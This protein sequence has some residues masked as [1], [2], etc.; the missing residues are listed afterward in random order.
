MVDGICRTH[1][2]L[3]ALCCA[4]A[5]GCSN[6]PWSDSGDD[7]ISRGFDDPNRQPYSALAQAFP[8]QQQGTSS[9]LPQGEPNQ[10]LSGENAFTT[11]F[12]KA[13]NA[14]TSALTIEPKVVPPDDPTS[15]AGGNQEPGADLH[16][17]AARVCES[18]SNVPAAAAHYQQS[19]ALDSKNVRTLIA[20]ARLLDRQANFHEAE[21]LYHQALQLEPDN[22]IASNDIGMM[23]ARQGMYDAALQALARAV[24]LQPA[25]QRYRNN[26][27][28][29]LIDAGRLDDAFM[30][31]AAVHG[32]AA[33]HYNLGYL[34]ARRGANNQAMQQLRLAI[35]LN[36]YLAPANQLLT[37]LSET[38]NQM[39]PSPPSHAPVN[40]AIYPVNERVRDMP[41][42]AMQPLPPI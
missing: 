9:P 33:A 6:S 38:A 31:L 28:I 11:S 32:E 25:N 18:Q 34:L 42:P 12:R 24:Q 30:H 20:Y 15:L 19:L 8:Q 26:I 5:T 16:Y 40:G 41:A 17:Y 10:S 1:Q 35:Q 7:Q 29:V 2:I 27:A 21:R 3:V 39:P 36:P 13:A 22:A 4:L 14:F 23:Y 37:Q